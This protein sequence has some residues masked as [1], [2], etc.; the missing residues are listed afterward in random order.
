MR[1][2]IMAAS[3]ALALTG[4]SL[5]WAAARPDT[6]TPDPKVGTRITITGCLHD[7]TAH[8]SYVLLG[9]T[10]RP[11]GSTGPILPEPW[12]I[13]WLDSTRGLKEHVGEMVDITGTVTERKKKPGTITIA[14][15]PSETRSTDVRVESGTDS[16]T[17][18]KFNDRPR[19]VGT[20]SAPPTLEVSR[21]VYILKVESIR[22]VKVPGASAPC[23]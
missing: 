16:A 12:V 20:S 11:A 23:R 17:T 9:V 7:G 19:P 18:E 10:E 6:A 22:T 5:L 8:D 2:I 1:R 14:I 15:D 4:S 3:M 13:Y 21:P